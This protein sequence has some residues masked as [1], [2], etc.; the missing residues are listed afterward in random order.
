MREEPALSLD[1]LRYTELSILGFNLKHSR[2]WGKKQVGKRRLAARS[3]T[4]C[5]L[6]STVY[7]YAK[8]RGRLSGLVR[9]MKA[10][11]R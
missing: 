5:T 11:W 7:L 1:R 2:S 3:R 9:W 4:S 8:G 10:A 6:W